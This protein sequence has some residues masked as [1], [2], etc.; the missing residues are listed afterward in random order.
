MVTAGEPSSAVAATIARSRRARCTCWTSALGNPLR[1][2]GKPRSLGVC[3]SNPPCAALGRLLMYGD[4]Q[5]TDANKGCPMLT[6]P[7]TLLAVTAAGCL[8]AGLA[9]AAGS[10]VARTNAVQL[11]LPTV[12]SGHRP[13]P[14][15]LYAPPPRAPQLENSG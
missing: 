2:R 1:P 6:R 4:V 7:R 12:T 14:D 15:V 5:V 9:T 11:G 8:V 10:S 13:G 3:A